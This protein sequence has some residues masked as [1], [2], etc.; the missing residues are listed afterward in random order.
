MRNETKIGKSEQKKEREIKKATTTTSE[1]KT[2]V[3]GK[4]KQ[5]TQ[6]IQLT[7][8]IQNENRIGKEENTKK[9]TELYD[10][11]LCVCKCNVKECFC[12]FVYICIAIAAIATSN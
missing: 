8:C 3:Y 2:N 6:T 9:N 1:G 4:S 11:F 12:L 7:A 10:S 5:V